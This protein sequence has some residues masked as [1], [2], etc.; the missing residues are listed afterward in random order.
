VDGQLAVDVLQGGWRYTDPCPL[1][2]A[3]WS[4]LEL[5][6]GVVLNYM[7]LM[8]YGNNR[9]YRDGLTLENYKT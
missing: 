4:V 2:S 7:D 6:G 9:L 5:G 1:L 8:Q 3:E